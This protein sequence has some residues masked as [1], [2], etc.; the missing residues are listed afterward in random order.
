MTLDRVSVEVTHEALI[1]GWPRLHTWLTDD[2]D[3]LRIHRQLTEAASTWD[4]LQRDPG[5]L[6]RGTRLAQADQWAIGGSDRVL[7][8]RERDFL[9]ASLAARA[10]DHAVARRR[11]RRLR[12][13]LALLSVL[14]VV[15]TAATGYASRA[16]RAT[17]AQRDAAIAQKVLSQAAALRFTNP[18]LALQL[19]LAAY[20]LVSLPEARDV[21][22]NSFATPYI[23][24]IAEHIDGLSSLAFSPDG[25]TLAVGGRDQRPPRHHHVL[26]RQRTPAPPGT[27]HPH[28]AV[29]VDVPGDVLTR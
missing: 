29:R 21:L 6:Y 4:A 13:L 8:A 12:Q 9:E 18:A 19:T 7:S 15:T 22:L 10:H 26:G 28:R 16:Q 5:T 2:R 3:G 23:I 11:T 27:R 17:T 20:R 1:R 14:L 24:R 25:K